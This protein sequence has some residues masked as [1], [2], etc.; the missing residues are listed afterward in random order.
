[1]NLDIKKLID[2]PGSS[3]DVSMLQFNGENANGKA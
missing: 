2:L 3:V 1:L